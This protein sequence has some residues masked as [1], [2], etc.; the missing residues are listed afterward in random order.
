MVNW[1]GEAAGDQEPWQAAIRQR[2]F[3]SLPEEFAGRYKLV[4]RINHAFR[5]E[6]AATLQG[7]LND[8]LAAMPQDSLAEKQALASWV[9]EHL[10]LLGLA[11]RC[12][13]TGLPGTLLADFQ[14]AAHEDTTRFRVE[15]RDRTGRRFKSYTSPSLFDL[16]LIEDTP[17]QE[18]L[19]RG[20]RRR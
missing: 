12:P 1:A 5:A 18:P 14:D 8:H 4:T 11:V 16:T 13:K 7:S 3:A 6:L 10:R 20:F 15:V 2:L 9:N 19:A 17:R